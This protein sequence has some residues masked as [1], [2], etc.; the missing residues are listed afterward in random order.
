VRCAQERVGC[1]TVCG[2]ML[3]C[4]AHH[5][6]R[7]C[8]TT[9]EGCGDCSTVCGKRRRLCLPL[10]HPCT[11]PCHAPSACDESAPCNAV[12]T[13]SCPCGRIRQ[14]VQCG[15]S[16]ANPA[17]RESQQLKCSNDCLVAKRNAR[18]ADALGITQESRERVAAVVWPDDVRAFGRANLKFVSVV[19]KAFA[20]FI[21]SEKKMQVL[22]H[23]P[24]DRR[25]FVHSVAAVYR[26]DTQMVDQEP[27]RS[28]QLLRRVDTKVPTP[29]LSGCL[30]ASGPTAS[31][32]KLADLRAG[33]S[34]SAGTGV[35]WRAAGATAKPPPAAVTGTPR[36]WG[37]AA[38][39]ST[40]P[41]STTV[42][43]APATRTSTP[44]TAP[45]V[46]AATPQTSIVVP[47]DLGR[48]C[49]VATVHTSITVISHIAPYVDE[50]LST[51]QIL[52]IGLV[53]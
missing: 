10:H 18:L 33:S 22:P 21:A 53:S 35:T 30:A 15:K 44:V 41:V 20:D 19:E 36:S 48:R 50:A 51:S 7:L 45:Q 6:E 27:H 16:L 47:E 49:L 14:Q 3:G 32:G 25:N 34:A 1:G 38:S 9:E 46:S 42:T 40:L 4:G 2:R 39:S 12:I 23:M 24:P 29:L 13:L 31:L 28:V 26:M 5:C 8:H 17:G 52:C 11:L 43:Q 37:A